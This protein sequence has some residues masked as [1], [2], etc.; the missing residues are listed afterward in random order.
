[1]ASNDHWTLDLEHL[2]MQGA[3]EELARLILS[4]Q[5]PYA[6]CVQGPDQSS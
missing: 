6:I 2:G 3:G 1:M 4:C 5:P